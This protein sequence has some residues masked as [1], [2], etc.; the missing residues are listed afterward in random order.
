M[1]KDDS[2]D[3]SLTR[4]Q[5]LIRLGGAAGLTVAGAFFGS[6]VIGKINEASRGSD[7]ACPKLNA[8]LELRH[9]AEGAEIRQKDGGRILCA[10]NAIGGAILEE[11]NGRNN[12]E[13]I[14][15]KA[16]ASLGLHIAD[17][18]PF[19]SGIAAFII[20]LGRMGLLQG[21]YY[22]RMMSSEVRT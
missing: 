9:T 21:P 13:A 17:P 22:V 19:R 15:E 20:E 2:K 5:F 3:K 10:A 14:G 16:A 18:E 7:P 8:A 6:L 4:R 11:M 12:L 1:Q